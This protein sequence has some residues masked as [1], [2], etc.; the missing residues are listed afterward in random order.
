MRP[1]FLSQARCIVAHLRCRPQ[2]GTRGM[3][4]RHSVPNITNPTSPTPATIPLASHILRRLR[5]HG[6]DALHGVPGDFTLP[7]L[8]YLRGAG[9]RWAG[10]CNELNA[11]YAADGYARVRGLGAVCTTYG[12]GELSAING[13]AGSYAERVPVVHIVGS[14][15]SELVESYGTGG[16]GQFKG[17]VH[18]ALGKGRS[19]DVYS[20]MARHVTADVVRLAEVPAELRAGRVDEAIR[21]CMLEKR[22]VYI[23][24]PSDLAALHVEDTTSKGL[25]EPEPDT[26][27]LSEAESS[28]LHILV[29]S[30]SRAQRPL[31]MVDGLAARF[32]L[33]EQL[34][35]FVRRTNVPTIVTTHALGVIDSHHPN[36]YGVYTGRLGDPQLKD[37][38][39]SSDFVM[40]FGELFSDTA[41]SGWDAVPNQSA[42]FNFADHQVTC[43]PEPEDPSQQRTYDVVVSRLLGKLLQQGSHNIG[44]VAAG[45]SLVQHL[46]TKRALQTAP[47]PTKPT[48]AITQ[49][50]LWPRLSA[51][52]RPHDTILLAN[53]T[54]LIGGA[55]FTLP[56]PVRVIASGLWF[57]IGQMLPAAQGAALAA[58]DAAAAQQTTATLMNAVSSAEEPQQQQQQQPVGR[59]ILLEGDGSF[60]TSAQELSTVMRNRLDMTILLVNN[61]GYAYERLILGPEAD[62][63]A[64]ADWRYTLAPEMMMGSGRQA[65]EDYPVLSER[66]ETVED[67]ERLLGDERMREPRGLKF[68]EVVMGETDVPSYFRPALAMSGGKLGGNADCEAR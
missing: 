45:K 20:Q 38:V 28:L 17:L 60:Q 22:P 4:S 23:D 14:P 41:T 65:L 24:L 43:N 46:P 40:L 19:L 55:M 1:R 64:V 2:P 18:H 13:I 10:N 44:Q 21:L 62:Y 68:V 52:F 27:V 33:S 54:P 50:Y 32:G 30:M 34:N 16:E 15:R 47:P 25:L 29:D 42:T 67:L 3:H 61:R 35:E 6:C 48:D 56:S 58:A 5:Q 66:V 57:S 36:Y 7:F 12:V 8:S 51:Y 49:D 9:V 37:Y 39:D 31:I 63:N 26:A 59:T 53:G 11:A